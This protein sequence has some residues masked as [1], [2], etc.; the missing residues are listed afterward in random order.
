MEK[1]KILSTHHQDTQ[2]QLV[3]KPISQHI[4]FKMII[5]GPFLSFVNVS[6]C[7]STGASYNVE[8]Q[9]L[10]DSRVREVNQFNQSIHIGNPFKV[11]VV[12]V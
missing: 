10:D 8:I 12:I 1:K 5:V 3:F 7:R 11:L 9:N 2:Y 4:F 6:T